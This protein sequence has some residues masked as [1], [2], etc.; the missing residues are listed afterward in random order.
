MHVSRSIVWTFVAGMLLMS[1]PA[2]AGDMCFSL[3]GVSGFVVYALKSFGAPG[4]GRCKP[5][6]GF[7]TVAGWV[8]DGTVCT[9][10]DGTAIRLAL[11]AHPVV[12]GPVTFQ[13]G[14]TIPLP[15]LTGGNCLGS[16]GSNPTQGFTSSIDLAACVPSVASVP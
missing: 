7:S 4:K 8:F 6:T 16:F 12:A 3:P 1:T 9:K 5:I 14:C 13:G 2:R 10:S 11:D 15:G